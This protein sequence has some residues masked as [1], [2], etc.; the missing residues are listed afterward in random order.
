LARRAMDTDV[1]VPISEI[2]AC[3]EGEGLPT[4]MP[5]TMVR[6]G[7]C[8]LKCSWCDSKYTWAKGWEKHV[9]WKTVQEVIDATKAA[10]PRNVSFTGGEPMLQAPTGHLLNIAKRMKAEAGIEFILIET[11]GLHAPTRVLGRAIDLW[12]LSPK[13]AGSGNW[14]AGSPEE[15][16]AWVW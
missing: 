7:G 6:F 5:V 3:I 9:E 13:L 11:N 2:Y 14:V 4:G 12:S 10:Y 8:D 16:A 15:T 1:R